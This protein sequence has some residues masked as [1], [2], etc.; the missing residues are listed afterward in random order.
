ML[1]LDLADPWIKRSL[2][3]EGTSFSFLLPPS[4]FFLLLPPPFFF[5]FFTHAWKMLGGFLGLHGFYRSR[6][7]GA[8]LAPPVN[9]HWLWSVDCLL[10]E[11]IMWVLNLFNS[12]IQRN[13]I[14]DKRKSGV[15][16]GLLLASENVLQR[17]TLHS[18][19][20]LSLGSISASVY[21]SSIVSFTF[22]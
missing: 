12:K 3:L 2:G 11:V 19:A 6:G 10:I 21:G 22:C 14:P 16:F 9:G 1:Q 17:A 4:F 15:Y 13:I 5:L 8:P 20:G 7:A 18:C